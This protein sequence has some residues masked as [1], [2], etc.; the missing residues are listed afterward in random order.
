GLERGDGLERLLPARGHRDLVAL[1][2]QELAEH[3]H[4]RRLV[5]HDQ[6]ARDHLVTAGGIRDGVHPRASRVLAHCKWMGAGADTRRR[7]DLRATTRARLTASSTSTVSSPSRGLVATA[8]VAL[9]RPTRAKRWSSS[10]R[11]RRSAQRTA[12]VLWVSGSRAA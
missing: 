12:G 5:V 3:V 4:D 9:T 1:G 7:P 6:H 2:G 8:A 11:R 10:V